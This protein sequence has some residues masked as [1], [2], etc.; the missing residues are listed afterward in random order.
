ME[1]TQNLAVIADQMKYTFEAQQ[2]SAAM[3]K[4][5]KACFM[6]MQENELLPTEERCLQ[7]CFIKLGNF[8]SYYD[9]ELSYAMRNLK[10]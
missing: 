9:K 5:T 4:C 8:G 7:N 6:S 10:L 2:A 1:K 3:A